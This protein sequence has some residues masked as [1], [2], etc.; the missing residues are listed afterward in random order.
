MKDRKFMKSFYDLKKGSLNKGFVKITDLTSSLVTHVAPSS[1]DSSW[2]MNEN[3][4]DKYDLSLRPEPKRHKT[5][6]GQ[7]VQDMLDGLK[8]KTTDQKLDDAFDALDH[9]MGPGA[10]K[11]K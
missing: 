8:N 5:W 6:Q 4:V 11:N 7:Y 10:K 1:S 9:F 2:K 3:A